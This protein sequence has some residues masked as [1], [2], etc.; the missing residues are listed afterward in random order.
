MVKQYSF[1][2]IFESNQ[3]SFAWYNLQ[4]SANDLSDYTEVDNAAKYYYANLVR[5]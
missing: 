4:A 3:L 1:L 2:L 5:C